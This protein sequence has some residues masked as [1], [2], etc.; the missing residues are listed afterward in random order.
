VL[1]A[2]VGVLDHLGFLPGE[3]L[4]QVVEMGFVWM[5]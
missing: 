2:P 1:G 3:L 4:F 5:R